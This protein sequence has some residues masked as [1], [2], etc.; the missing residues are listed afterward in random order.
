[1]R[2]QKKLASRVFVGIGRKV[3]DP[4]NSLV[5]SILEF[6]EFRQNN[7]NIP[8]QKFISGRLVFFIAELSPG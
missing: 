6:L 4:F 7:Q 3:V 2:L 1:M 5:E 8:A